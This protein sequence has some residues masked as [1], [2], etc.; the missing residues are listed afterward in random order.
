M[1]LSTECRPRHWSVRSWIVIDLAADDAEGVHVDLMPLKAP[2]G[3]STE[4]Q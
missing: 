1:V 2:S 3:P 4:V